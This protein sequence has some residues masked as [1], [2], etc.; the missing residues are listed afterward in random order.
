MTETVYLGAR[1][2]RVL[3]EKLD[4]KA[5]RERRSIV[6]QLKIILEEALEKR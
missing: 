4:A 5:A 2:P 3:K 1:I 6:E